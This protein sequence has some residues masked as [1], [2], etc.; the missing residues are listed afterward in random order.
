MNYL[1]SWISIIIQALPRHHRK[2][3]FIKYLR[4]TYK[5]INYLYN[6]FFSYREESI[7]KLRYTGQVVYLEHMLNAKFNQGAPAYTSGAPTGIWIGSGS[8]D[9]DPPYLFKKEEN[10]TDNRYLYDKTETPVED[11][12]LIWLYTKEELESLNYDFTVNVPD[13]LGDVNTTTELYFAVR[14]WVNYY[15][16]AGKSFIIQNYTP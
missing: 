10:L 4:A 15:R 9:F 6:E 12:D 16:Q 14:A 13:A 2:V 8:I 7:F 1:V 5:P 3:R 11:S